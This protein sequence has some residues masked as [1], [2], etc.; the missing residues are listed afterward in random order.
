MPNT[1][2]Q[3]VKLDSQI[4]LTYGTASILESHIFNWVFRRI[5]TVCVSA[6]SLLGLDVRIARAATHR[7]SFTRLFATQ[8]LQ[9]NT[10]LLSAIQQTKK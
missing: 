3:N 4:Q 1:T 2:A 6:S 7:W 5:D 9:L 8:H 10:F